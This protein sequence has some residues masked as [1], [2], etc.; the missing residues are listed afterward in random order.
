MNQSYQCT[1]WYTPPAQESHKIY[2]FH[3]LVVLGNEYVDADLRVQDRFFC[4]ARGA[5]AETGE[6]NRR[7]SRRISLALVQLYV[8]NY[9]VAG[10]S[11]EVREWASSR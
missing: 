11:L 5:L 4:C 8:V 10:P 2:T 9:R 7:Y 6:R 3:K 1:I